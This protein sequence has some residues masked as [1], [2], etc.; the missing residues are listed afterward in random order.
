MSMKKITCHDL[1]Y[2][3]EKEFYA[4]LHPVLERLRREYKAFSDKT[5]QQE[6]EFFKHLSYSVKVDK[7]AEVS[8]L[9]QQIN[10]R[11]NTDLK[12]NLFLYQSPIS[13]ACCIPR[14]G[15]KRS[16]TCNELVI[17]VS[18][19]FLNELNP[20]EQT[21][22]L[23]HELGH[24]VYGHVDIPARA[25][26]D[27]QFPLKDAQALKSNLLKWMI[28]AEVSCDTVAYLSCGC[29][30]NAF[31]TAML[32][33][34]TG[35]NSQNIQASNHHGSLIDVVSEQFEEIS[36]H[37][38]NPILTTHPL[39]PL[40]LRIA[41]VLSDSGLVK[42]FGKSLHEETLA[43][44]KSEFNDLIDK[45]VGKIYPEIIPAKQGPS[46]DMLFELC[47]AVASAD[48]KITFDEVG[49]IRK[50]LGTSAK[51]EEKYRQMTANLRPASIADMASG[52]VNK[53]VLQAEQENY[54]KG[55]IVK[56]LRYLLIV[57]AS[58][59]KIEN[60]ELDTIY[61]FAK[62]FDVSKQEILL[63]FKQM[64]FH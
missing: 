51:V 25:V 16:E 54:N 40:R 49:A 32:K 42:H 5:Q 33:Y 3:R 17:L 45:E 14:Y 4:K 2:K 7:L 56:I 12:I 53:A 24:L 20:I 11:L 18:Q 38:F 15:V 30:K 10:N 29:D 58:D 64:G 60:C 22:V 36:G 31:C 1:Q 8:Y 23:G 34:T 47:I 28:C 44:Y 6:K 62:R 43:M 39:T 35:L 55:D 27:Y 63:L 52:I 13:N 26:L 59:G 21:A 41:S 48:G 50:I 57:A 37:L 19:H 9:L 61:A 46:N